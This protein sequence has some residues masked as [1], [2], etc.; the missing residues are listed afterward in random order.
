MNTYIFILEEDGDSEHDLW[1]NN[2]V[3]QFKQKHNILHYVRVLDHERN[4][5]G[6]RLLYNLAVTKNSK[7]KIYTQD[8]SREKQKSPAKTTLTAPELAL[9]GNISEPD[10]KKG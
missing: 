7:M 2:P 6:S 3:K 10:F 9:K 1:G 4:N 8:K 5:K